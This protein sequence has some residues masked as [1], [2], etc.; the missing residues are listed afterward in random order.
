[1]KGPQGDAGREKMCANMQTPP[2]VVIHGLAAWIAGAAAGARPPRRG[3]RGHQQS[4][5]VGGQAG[6]VWPVMPT[7]G[8]SRSPG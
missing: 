8:R 5:L 4:H 2:P 6:D 1:M 7:S 3:G